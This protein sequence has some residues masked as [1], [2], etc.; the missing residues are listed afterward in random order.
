MKPCSET[1]YK[2]LIYCSKCYEDK[3]IQ[4]MGEEAFKKFSI[5]IAKNAFFKSI[6]NMK[7]PEFRNFCLDNYDLITGVA[8][9]SDLD[10]PN[11][12]EGS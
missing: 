10:F 9:N 7:N 3:L 5:S 2:M 1:T 8:D 6:V 12:T 4:L 11:S